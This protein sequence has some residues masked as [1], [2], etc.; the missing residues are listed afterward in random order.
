[1]LLPV[2]KEYEAMA[3]ERAP[4]DKDIFFDLNEMWSME[5]RQNFVKLIKIL[6]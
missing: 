3:N 1:M 5:T 4:R 2:K 6:L